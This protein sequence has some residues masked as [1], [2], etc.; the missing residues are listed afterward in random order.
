MLTG[1]HLREVVRREIGEGAKVAEMHLV[2]E[3]VATCTIR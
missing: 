2:E 3:L 1:G